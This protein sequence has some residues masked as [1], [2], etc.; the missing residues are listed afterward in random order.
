MTSSTP[1]WNSG[2]GKHLIES[3]GYGSALEAAFA[4]VDKAKLD[5]LSLPSDP[6]VV[7]KETV[8]TGPMKQNDALPKMFEKVKAGG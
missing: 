4:A 7:L 6:E 2:S 8:F 5:E 1:A 3:H